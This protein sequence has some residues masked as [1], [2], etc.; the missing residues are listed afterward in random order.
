MM[1][2]THPV[3]VLAFFA[4]MLLNISFS[5]FPEPRSKQLL[6]A[7]PRL[8]PD[9]LEVWRHHQQCFALR[10]KLAERVGKV[11]FYIHVNRRLKE[12]CMPQIFDPS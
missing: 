12:S 8:P 3:S 6:W 7:P 9:V 2:M 10:E 1:I 4:F 11:E 5:V